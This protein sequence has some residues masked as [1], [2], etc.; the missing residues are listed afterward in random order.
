MWLAAGVTDIEKD[1]AKVLRRRGLVVRHQAA[2]RDG[3]GGVDLYAT[4]KDGRGW[5]IQCKC[6]GLHRPVGPEVVRELHGAIAK[7]DIGGSV[8]SRGILIT[9]SRFT[10]SV[11]SSRLDDP[12]GIR[13][14]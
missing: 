1:C 10:V 5:V 6:W 9:T 13:G 4:D 12:S 7:A 14:R 3:D 8:P 2:Q 11:R